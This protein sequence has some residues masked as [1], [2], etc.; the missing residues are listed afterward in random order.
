MSKNNRTR[1]Y[2]TDFRQLARLLTL[3]FIVVLATISESIAQGEK[4][5]SVEY[6]ENGLRQLKKAKSENSSKGQILAHAKIAHHYWSK[7]NYP[8]ALEHFLEAISKAEESKDTEAIIGNASN[9]G[10]VYLICSKPEEALPYLKQ[11]M[12]MAEGRNDTRW[13]GYV[14]GKLGIAEH[15]LGMFDSALISF[16]RSLALSESVGDTLTAIGNVG[17]IGACYL[18][19]HHYA[20]AMAY[21][22]K[23]L[24]LNR[25]IDDKRGEA[26][27]LG[28]IG[29]T[30]LR[31]AEDSIHTP[32]DS[33]VSASRQQ[34]LKSAVTYLEQAL[35]A[36]KKINYA[37]GIASS[38]LILSRALEL[39]EKYADALGAFK[40][41]VDANE[42]VRKGEAHEELARIENRRV[43]DLKEKDLTIANIS[44]AGKRKERI[45][46]VSGIIMLIAISGIL[47]VSYRRQKR[48]GMQISEAKKQSDD[49]LLNIL[50]SEVAEEL[51]ATGA[52]RTRQFDNVTVLL[53]DF[54]DFT[55][56]G[57]RM[58]PDELVAELH[59]CFKA[60][61]DI[62]DRY[63]IE[64]IK[65]IGD[66][67]LAVCGLPNA[68]LHHAE[69]AVKA[70]MEINHFMQER[71]RILGDRT[72]RIRIG[73]HSGAV[74]AGIVG[75]RKFAY[76][77]WGDTVNTAAR[78]EQSSEPGRINISEATYALVKDKYKCEYRGEIEAKNKGRL[79]MFFVSEPL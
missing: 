67:Y 44:L 45:F 41:G 20:K 8:K 36:S 5:T 39:Q 24:D 71:F 47:A 6:L 4:E 25:Q 52:A 46:L 59:H 40:E 48:A 32:A 78:M 3:L 2:L 15:E 66:A 33:L 63:G 69:N 13:M 21:H 49:L 16:T 73:V 9:I 38:A 10:V 58:R 61:D 62:A 7:E 30:Y 18:E 76:D 56:A 31:I 79:S 60:F 50:P 35:T 42:T 51:K 26:I 57:E 72:F 22:F 75:A 34:N 53:T 77:I 70:A 12:A 55:R 74:V 28:N 65:T 43:L 19:Q 64:K 27:A 1:S 11:S 37:S 23:Y 17:N 29:E 14:L 54:V 68:N